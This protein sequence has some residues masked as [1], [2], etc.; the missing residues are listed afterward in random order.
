MEVNAPGTDSVRVGGVLIEAI[1]VVAGGRREILQIIQLSERAGYSRSRMPKNFDVR[2]ACA[3]RYRRR[4]RV[5]VVTR[6]F[7]LP[8]PS[9]PP[10][11]SIDRVLWLTARP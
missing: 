11:A 8:L 7:G 1:I 2:D 10:A 6:P 5:R 4:E 3:D 9:A